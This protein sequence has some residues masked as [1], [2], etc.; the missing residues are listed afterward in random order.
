MENEMAVEKKKGKKKVPNGHN[1]SADWHTQTEAPW[2]AGFFAKLL[3]KEGLAVVL[4]FLLLGA[5]AYMYKDQRSQI[6]ARDKVFVSSFEKITKEGAASRAT[7]HEGIKRALEKSTEVQ[8]KMLDR[9]DDL[10]LHNHG[11][12]R[13]PPKGK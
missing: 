11:G 7:E 12:I 9:L 10:V 2:W 3:S 13:T 6:E 8:Q 5:M 4:V 1:A